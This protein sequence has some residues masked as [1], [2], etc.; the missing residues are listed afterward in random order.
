[1]GRWMCYLGRGEGRKE[2]NEWDSEGQIGAGVICVWPQNALKEGMKTWRMI[3]MEAMWSDTSYW[4]DRDWA[5]V[6]W[7]TWEKWDSYVAV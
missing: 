2:E 4:S 6:K 3:K 5:E 7:E 1:M